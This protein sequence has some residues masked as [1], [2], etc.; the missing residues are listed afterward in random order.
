MHEHVRPPERLTIAYSQEYPS[1]RG[2]IGLNFLSA[3]LFAALA[4]KCAARGRLELGE[5]IDGGGKAFV[6]QAV[7]VPRV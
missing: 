5:G 1:C 6:V 4:L 7:A 2:I 3:V